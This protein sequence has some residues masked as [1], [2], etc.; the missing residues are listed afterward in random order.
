M[1]RSLLALRRL[2]RAGSRSHSVVEIPEIFQFH[3]SLEP[4]LLFAEKC[5][6]FIISVLVFLVLF[7]PL[8]YGSV[9]PWAYELVRVAVL[10]LLSAFLM[11]KAYTRDLRFSAP[12]FQLPALLFL[13]LLIIQLL[14]IPIWLRGVLSPPPL[15][16]SLLLPLFPGSGQTPFQSNWTQISLYPTAT[17]EALFDFSTCLVLIWVIPSAIRQRDSQRSILVS[18]VGI[19][20]FQ[21]LYG[22]LEY[23]SGRQRIFLF[24]KMHYREDVTGTYINHNHFA[25][26]MDLTI[27]ILTVFLW[28]AFTAQGDLSTHANHERW[29]RKSILRI[30][31]LAVL[32][33]AMLIGLVLSHSRGGLFSVGTSL[34]LLVFLLFKQK[35]PSA[36]RLTTLILVAVLLIMVF[37][38]GELISRFS[39]SFRDAP[40]RIGVWKDAT[41]I[42]KDFPLWGTGIGTFKY[43]LPN[44]RQKV[45]I[46]MV[47]GVPRQASWNFAHNDYLQLLAECGFLGLVLAGWAITLWFRQFHSRIESILNAE[48]RSIRYGLAC[49][50]FALLIHSFMDFNLHI[51]ANALLF[52]IC[53]SLATVYG[54]NEI[55]AKRKTAGTDHLVS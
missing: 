53:L 37:L 19:G 47:D 32:L 52:T 4:S 36:N 51:P 5:D 22:L 50:V 17:W 20:S 25:G 6:R 11:R 7:S 2:I 28:T 12:S 29:R 8:A 30:L 48:D 9:D 41:K 10:L 33:S 14:P 54:T 40:E 46:L 55:R 31:T 24:T 42:A 34:L 44:Y 45:D 13:L 26:L 3:P 18:I 15:N 27:P 35:R 39:Y 1:T 43:V 23:F 49:S 16:H 38:S 21:A